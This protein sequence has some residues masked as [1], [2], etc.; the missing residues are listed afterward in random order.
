MC[1]SENI[2]TTEVDCCEQGLC[3]GLSEAQGVGKIET[4]AAV[5]ANITKLNSEENWLI[6]RMHIERLE[7]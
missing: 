2:A 6:I 1:K 7:E 4:F 3:V 5:F